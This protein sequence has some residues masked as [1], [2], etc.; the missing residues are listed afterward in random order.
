MGTE[1]ARADPGEPV[2]LTR[3][4][5]DTEGGQALGFFFLIYVKKKKSPPIS[6]T[7]VTNNVCC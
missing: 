4:Q 3:G 1:A 2:T 6:D 5:G 7:E